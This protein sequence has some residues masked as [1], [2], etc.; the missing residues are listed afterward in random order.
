MDMR[1]AQGLALCT[2][3][4][5]SACAGNG[6][7]LD[8]NGRP[9]DEADSSL[10]PTF[11]SI[12]RNVL[13]AVCTSCHS[14]AGAP[15]S[16]RLDEGAAYALLVNVPSVEAPTILRVQP[17]DPDAS[18]LVQKLE[19]TAQVGA[20]MP[21]DQPPL[22]AETIAVIRQWIADGAQN[23]VSTGAEKLTFA[24]ELVGVLPMTDAVLTSA[25]AEI[26]L[27]ANAALDLALLQAGV[28]TLSAS[29]G[30]DSFNEGNEHVIDLRI[31]VRSQ[32]PTVLA[33][34]PA[35]PLRAGETYVVRVSGSQPIAAA[36]L[37]GRPIDG[38]ADGMPGGDFVLRFTVEDAP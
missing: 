14:G 13:T 8:E 25:P 31:S 3:A 15:L 11:D 20:R 38:D 27:S 24:T 16:L 30:D 34:T 32:E 2:F 7:G 22:P 33:L 10:Q 23:D 28:V 26:V 19:G 9:I 29:G 35:T 12:Q 6:E 4:V 36:D 18:Y 17:G 5:L 37:Q 21:L 1:A